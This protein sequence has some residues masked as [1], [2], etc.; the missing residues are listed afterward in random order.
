MKS[1]KGLWA[2]IISLVL[3]AGIALSGQFIPQGDEMGFTLAFIYIA[4]PLISLICGYFVGKYLHSIKWVYPF[5]AA[6]SFVLV[7]TAIFYFDLNSLIFFL[8]FLPAAVGV[9]IPQLLHKKAI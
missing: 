6:L 1:N 8:A 3:Y 5:F 9:F 2:W 7:T 4:F